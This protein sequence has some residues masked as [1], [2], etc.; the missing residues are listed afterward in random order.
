MGF[1]RF[2]VPT[3]REWSDIETLN[4]TLERL[5]ARRRSQVS[6]LEFPRAKIAWKLVG[7]QQVCLYRTV[8]LADA[9]ASSWNSGNTLGAMV[10]ARALMETAAVLHDLEAQLTRFCAD[11]NL[12]AVDDLVMRRTFA[13]RLKDWD[14]GAPATNILTLLG[15]MD[16]PFKGITNVYELLCEFCHPNSLGTF[17]LFSALDRTELTA[18]FTD[19]CQDPEGHFSNIILAFMLIEKVERDVDRID[20]LLPVVV[21]LNEKLPL[22]RNKRTE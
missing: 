16:P 13:T 12:D 6:G 15:K 5:R 17:H 4:A 9:C 10:A 2:A 8:M 22:L 14:W 3:S 7:L 20:D 18:Y 11:E 19:K 1:D 21:K